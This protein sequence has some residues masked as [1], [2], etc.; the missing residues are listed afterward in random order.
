MADVI[1]YEP[2]LLFSSKIEAAAAKAG[3]HVKVIS[4]LDGFLRELE[5]ASRVVFLNLDAVEGKFA[6]L[7]VLTKHVP[8]RVVGYHSHVNTR[9]AEEA[10][11]VGIG[12]VLSRG[13]FVRR[14]DEIL[15]EFSSG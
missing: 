8:G 11:R 3:L 7:E 1:A 5:Q 14:L 2:D 15:K 9:V 6:E 4:D 10:R 12:V 13:V